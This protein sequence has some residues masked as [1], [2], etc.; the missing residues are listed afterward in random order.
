M[1]VNGTAAPPPELFDPAAGALRFHGALHNAEACAGAL[2][3]LRAGGAPP[4]ALVLDLMLPGLDGMEVAGRLRA[5]SDVPIIM[6]TARG[7]ELVERGPAL[8]V[9]SRRGGP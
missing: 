3:A 7:E 8:I 2:R 6:L 1:G 5:A 9:P 4:D